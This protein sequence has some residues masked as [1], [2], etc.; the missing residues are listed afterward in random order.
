M[1]LIITSIA[2]PITISAIA[3]SHTRIC[4]KIMIAKPKAMKTTPGIIIHKL[5]PRFS[6]IPLQV[7]A[8][9]HIGIGVVSGIVLPI[10][11]DNLPLTVPNRQLK[12]TMTSALST[13]KMLR[14][15]RCVH[16]LYHRLHWTKSSKRD[17]ST[18]E[19]EKCSD[20]E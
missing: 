10:C 7:S 12:E 3:T 11:W 6:I 9:G 2:M 16:L 18:D 1:K 14:H 13:K 19:R 8:I 15:R 4:G 5:E 17:I 20:N